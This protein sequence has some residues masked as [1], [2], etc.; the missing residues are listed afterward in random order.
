MCEPAT[1]STFQARWTSMKFGD[2]RGSP[3]MSGARC[4]REYPILAL[5]NRIVR[6]PPRISAYP[7]SLAIAVLTKLVARAPPREPAYPPA[8]P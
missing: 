3:E 6:S 8:N 5:T 7:N 4:Y 2:P 1:C